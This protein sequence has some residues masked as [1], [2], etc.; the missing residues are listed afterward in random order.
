[1]TKQIPS[2]VAQKEIVEL[3]EETFDKVKGIYLDGG[4]SLFETLSSVSA[5]EA[6][7]PITASGTSIAAQVD[8][9]RFYLEAN[10]DY[11]RGV[12]RGKIDWKQSWRDNEVSPEEWQQLIVNLREERDRFVELLNNFEDWTK[13]GNLLDTISAAVHSAYHLGAI[14]QILRVVKERD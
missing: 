11:I 9:I 13:Q 5:E 2:E 14:R 12:D 10:R 7:I 6:S 3:L 8:H 4:T 1:M